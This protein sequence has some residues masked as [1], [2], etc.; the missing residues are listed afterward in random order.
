MKNLVLGIATA[1]VLLFAASGSATIVDGSVTSGT[2]SWIYLADP[3]GISVGNDTFDDPNLRGFDEDQNILLGEDTDV[4]TSWNW[5]NA[6]VAGTS[7]TTLA[8]GTE[9]AS[10]YI[11]FDPDGNQGIDGWIEFDA[12]VLGILT[13]T[14]T[15]LATDSLIN[16]SVTYLNPSLRGLEDYQDWVRID[17][18]N[19]KRIELHFFASTP[20]D[21]IRVLTAHSVLA[22]LPEPSG[23][24]LLAIG[25]LLLLRRRRH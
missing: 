3:S 11:A 13:D 5:N 23:L 7:S 18:T 4:F 8:S 15:L 16:N 6:T 12:D 1:L 19:S 14:D 9:V 10:H 22:E 17:P 21:Y 20:G 2:G 25:A 24:V